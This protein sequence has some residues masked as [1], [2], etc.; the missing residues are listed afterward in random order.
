MF[1][2][3]GGRLEVEGRQRKTVPRSSAIT[4]AAILNPI[5]ADGTLTPR[6]AAIRF[7]DGVA[8]DVA[9]KLE[10]YVAACKSVSQMIPNLLFVY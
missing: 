4:H 7:T 5:L 1:V 8:A 3:D 9:V 10:Q 2:K 6:F